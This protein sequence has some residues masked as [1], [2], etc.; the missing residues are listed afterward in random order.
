MGSFPEGFFKDSVKRKDCFPKNIF[1]Q[2]ICLAKCL[3]VGYVVYKIKFLNFQISKTKFLMLYVYKHKTSRSPIQRRIILYI[4][5]STWLIN[6][7]LQ[8]SLV[9]MQLVRKTYLSF[10]QK[11]NKFARNGFILLIPRTGHQQNSL[12][13]VTITFMIHL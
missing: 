7:L 11:T 9:V 6:V 13:Y 8:I 3:S 1:L 2:N 10:F 4:I 12:L 5:I